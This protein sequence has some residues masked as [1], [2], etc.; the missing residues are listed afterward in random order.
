[1][2]KLAALTALAAAALLA[3]APT[4]AEP[5][6]ILVALGYGEIDS[7][8]DLDR[9]FSLI[10]ADVETAAT[11]AD[12]TRLYRRARYLVTLTHAPAWREKFGDQTPRIIAAADA[13][14]KTTV[15][16]INARARA[17]GTEADYDD[18]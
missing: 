3:A 1:M 7:A 6:P 13:E 16:A 5:R 10:R 17:I 8:A 15:Q 14:L 12:L 18:R 9:V 11:R 2:I 4:L